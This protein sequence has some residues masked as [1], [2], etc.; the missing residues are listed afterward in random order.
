MNVKF[1]SVHVNKPSLEY[2]KRQLKDSTQTEK[3][4]FLD[5]TVLI[6]KCDIIY[7]LLF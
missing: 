2:C 6:K 5:K 4:L 3:N 7:Y 1:D